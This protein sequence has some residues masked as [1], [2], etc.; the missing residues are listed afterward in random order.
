MSL[1]LLTIESLQHEAGAFARAE[2]A[3]SEKSLFSVNDGKTIGTWLE[4]RF[5]AWLDARYLAQGGNAALGIDLPSLNVDIKSTSVRQPQSSCPFHSARQKVFGLGYSLLVFVYE[6][7]D[8][9]RRKTARL[10]IQHVI[11]IDAAATGDF[12]MSRRL[13]EMVRDGANREDIV[14][15]LRDRHLPVDDIEAA[16][17]ADE[18]IAKPPAQGALTI[19]NAL[20]WRLQYGHALELMGEAPGVLRVGGTR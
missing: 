3:R 17:I 4:A 18:V 13:R 8:D 6:K 12:T 19:S 20:Q 2:S 9:T 15:F 1:P 14:G 7:T 10:E 16:R 11:F 5:R